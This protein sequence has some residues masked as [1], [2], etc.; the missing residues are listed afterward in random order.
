MRGFDDDVRRAAQDPSTPAIGLFGLP[1]DSGVRLNSGRPGAAHG[2]TAFRTAFARFGV[3]EPAFALTPGRHAIAKPMPEIFDFGDVAMPE[4]L[5]KRDRLY[6]SPA[7]L[8]RVHDAVSAAA[9]HVAATG[10]IPVAIGGGH[11]LTF[12]FL[13]G[14]FSVAPRSAA[15]KPPR[16]T[17]AARRS[18]AARHALYV[19]PHLDVRAEPGS[20]MPFRSLI[21]SGTLARLTNIGA[22]PMVN[23][24]QHAAWFLS[25]GGRV[26]SLPANPAA[27]KRL[28][29]DVDAVSIDLD[30]LDAAHAPGVSALN[31]VGFSPRELA[32]LLR[33]AG[34]SPSVRAIDF[35][36]LC[37]R[38]DP[39]GQT[40]RAAVF[41]FLCFLQGLARRGA[42][43]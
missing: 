22:Q 19:D 30:A 15:A 41:L 32:P 2:P 42:A 17:P 29:A 43:S 1:D 37:P 34:E 13:R 36:E 31:P 8:Q 23:T 18:T 4:P 5:T 7:H 25:H 16:R 35:M 26:A 40:A 11:D 10:L 3:A 27:A 12:A 6:P 33:A 28:L 20:G 9:A 39:A 14:V 38:F 21:E 24:A